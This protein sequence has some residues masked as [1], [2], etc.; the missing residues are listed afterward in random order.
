[1]ANVTVDPLALATPVLRPEIAEILDFASGEFLDA[2]AYIAAKRY[3]QLVAER[4]DI[5]EGLDNNPRF[6]CA[7]CATP[8][9]LVA[10][11]KK[12][13]FFRH[14]REDGSCPS[15]TRSVLSRADIQALKY[16]GQRESLAHLRTKDRIVRSLTCDLSNSEIVSERQWRS[17]RDPAS[18]RQPDVQA[19]TVFGRVAFE[20]QLSTTFLDVVVGRRAFYRDEGAL[21]VWI[22]AGFDPDYRRMTTD[23]LL[24]SNNSNILVVDE[25]TTARSEES[26]TFHVRVHYRVPELSNGSPV[27]QW[28]STIC[29]FRDLTV[30]LQAQT[31]FDYQGQSEKLLKAEMEAIARADDSLRERLF[32]FWKARNQQTPDPVSREAAWQGLMRDISA[33]GVTPPTN[34]RYDR[35]ITGL[36]NG[37]LSAKEGI[38]IGWDFKHL[39][40][41]AHRICDGYPEHVLTM[42]YAIRVYGRETLISAQDKSG[43]WA[44][45]AQ[46]IRKLILEGDQRYLP[47]KDTLSFLKFVFP[48]VGSKVEAFLASDHAKSRL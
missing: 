27:D 24:F 4:V 16:D 19:M 28:E 1:M 48:E 47:D 42:G 6:G 3:D 8:V 23:D 31:A 22:M 29:A 36:M 33:R 25:E 7:L 13:F 34:D 10:S 9:Y 41:V 38:P 2:A 32:K 30:D 21:L 35:A 45:R 20:A 40:E 5:R 26:G 44:K 39:V 12:R 17:A 15:V 46:S 11:G 18:R 14:R 37:M 43:K